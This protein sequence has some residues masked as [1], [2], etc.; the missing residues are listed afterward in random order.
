MIKLTLKL[1]FL[2]SVILLWAFLMI[3]ALIAAPIVNP[4][5]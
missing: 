5:S 4:M 3:A 1:A 2:A